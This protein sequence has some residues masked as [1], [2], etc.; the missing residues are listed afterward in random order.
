MPLVPLQADILGPDYRVETI[1]LPPDTEGPVVATL[2][3]LEPERSNGRAVLHV[4]GFADYFFHTEYAEWWAAR[5]YTFYA[6]DLRKYG[7][8]I[9]AH[10][11]PNYVA[12]LG[13]YHA[14]I[15]LAW[16]RI[17]QRDGHR[18]V[19][20]SGH[21]TGGLTVPLWVHERRP[22][23]LVAMV[24]NSP[25]F[26]MQGPAWL[27]SPA[28]RVAIERIGT[29]RPLQQIPRR[30]NGVYGRSLHRDHG[31]E[32][33]YDLDWKPLESRPVYV[34]WLRA[35]RRGHAMLHD[36]L[37]IGVPTLVLSSARSWFGAQT[38]ETAATHDIVLDVQQIRHW[39]SSVGRHVTSVAIEGA[40]HDVV[41][42]RPGP[43][44]QAYAAM[45]T[46]LDAWVPRP[47]GEQDDE[48]GDADHGDHR[49]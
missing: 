24:L 17:T 35:I 32:W 28:A 9:R 31:G 22:A 30:I 43:R 15:D 47:S 21:S 19:V 5:G 2:V 3:T 48:G 25:W 29:S 26:D 14:E 40:M 16:W 38:D 23:E 49:A 8:S 41:L 11:T 34:G 20:A 44:A 13:E 33:D 42:S 46:W 39:A 4:H 37:D 18:E 12:D 7:R 6:L 10:Q 45:S 1:S 36:G 27:R